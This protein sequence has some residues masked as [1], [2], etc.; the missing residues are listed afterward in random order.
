MAEKKTVD[1]AGVE[2]E[3]RAGVKTLRVIGADFGVSHVA[4]K[5]RADK[6]K[7]ARDLSARI[8]ERTAQ[9]VNKAAVTK[10]VNKAAVVSDQVVVEAN[11]EL[12][13]QVILSHRTD[14]RAL[15]ASIV[16]MAGEL[17]AA[18]K[19]ELQDALETILKTRTD[20]MDKQGIAALERAF[21]AALSL[22]GRA[23][24]G[25][26]LANALATLIDKERIAF[27]IDER[28]SA[29]DEVAEA[30]KAIHGRS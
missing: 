6:E 9:K 13:K 23:T 18:N 8:K 19:R 11:A 7:W 26:R 28:S 30:L 2:R 16:E 27:S 21:D 14:L 15:R 5:K 12:Q 1:W 20:G 29:V 17:S 24:A 22:G 3:F 4:I 10:S 25:Q